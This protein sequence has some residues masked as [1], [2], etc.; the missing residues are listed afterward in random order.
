MDGFALACPDEVAVG[1]VSEYF[2]M[3]FEAIRS[4]FLTPDEL[5]LDNAERPP[6]SRPPRDRVPPV[7][8]DGP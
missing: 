8:G 7:G 2:G 6:A 3:F 5:H 4:V 1:R